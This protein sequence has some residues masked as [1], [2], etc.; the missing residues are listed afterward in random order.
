M[1][2][3]APAEN[4]FSIAQAEMED[5]GLVVLEG[6][7][8]LFLL[9]ANLSTSPLS[10]A[11]ALTTSQRTGLPQLRGDTGN[12]TWPDVVSLKMLLPPPQDEDPR[13]F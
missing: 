9:S 10:E 6:V 1:T 3:Q 5:L 13:S 12:P 7:L 11:A 8:H 4:L 2:T